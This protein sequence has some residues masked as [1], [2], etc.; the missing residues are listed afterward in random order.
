MLKQ[1]DKNPESLFQLYRFIEQLIEANSQYSESEEIERQIDFL[2]RSEQDIIA[3]LS[4]TESNSVGDL[5]HKISILFGETGICGRSSDE[6]LPFER[7]AQSVLTDLERMTDS[8]KQS[9]RLAGS[10]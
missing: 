2:L 8:N 6:L 9:N 1:S 10:A 7:L 5:K 3:E 4:E